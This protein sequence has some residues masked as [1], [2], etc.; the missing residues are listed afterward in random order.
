MPVVS[1]FPSQTKTVY[2]GV[3]GGQEIKENTS[4][5]KRLQRGFSVYCLRV[6]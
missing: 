5:G 6:S 1:F 4:G 3:Q 2:F